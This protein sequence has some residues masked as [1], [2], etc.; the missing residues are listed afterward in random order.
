MFKR[1]SKDAKMRKCLGGCD[2]LFMS[3][4]AANRICSSCRRAEREPVKEYRL[5]N[6]HGRQLKP[7]SE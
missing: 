4:D 1:A 3:T 2:K 6:E 5:R 7:P